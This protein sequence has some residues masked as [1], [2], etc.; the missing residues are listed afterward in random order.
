MDC[1]A[2]GEPVIDRRVPSFCRGCWESIRPLGLP[3]CPYCGRP[4]ESPLAL[5]HSPGHICGACRESPPAFDLAVAP[6]RYD[7][8][9]ERA[10]RLYKYRKQPWFARP[11]AELLLHQA[12]RLPPCDMVLAVPLHPSRLRGREFNQA[13]LLAERI[14]AHLQRPLSLDHL[15]RV[16]PTLPQTQLDRKERTRN[17]RNAFQVRRPMDLQDRAILLVDDVLT[18]RATVNECAKALRGATVK[19]VVVLA[20]AQRM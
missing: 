4:F 3:A 5:I 10:I 11:L 15:I 9:L 17:V 2:C 14:A 7:G 18:T 8:I 20:L 16:R 1:A 12:E 13:L 6:Y 19:S